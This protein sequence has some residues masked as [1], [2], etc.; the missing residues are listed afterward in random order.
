M[1]GSLI[2][3]GLSLVFF[4]QRGFPPS[5]LLLDWAGD[6]L[7]LG[8]N[9]HVRAGTP[10]ESFDQGRRPI[11][12]ARLIRASNGAFGIDIYSFA[13]LTLSLQDYI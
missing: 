11:D 5:L 7:I 12:S 1:V 10:R 6:I 2:F 8:R 13:I 4:E 3:A 9:P